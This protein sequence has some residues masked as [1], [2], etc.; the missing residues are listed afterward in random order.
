MSHTA[1]EPIEVILVGELGK[2]FGKKW[3]LHAS[4][5]AQALRLINVNRRGMREY[6]VEAAQRGEKYHVISDD[7]RRSEAELAL[8]VKRRLVIAPAV[9]GAGGKLGAALELVAAA[10]ILVVAWW[11][12]G[13][14]AASTQLSVAAL[15][16]SLALSG[17]TQLLTSIPKAGSGQT[18][19]LQSNYFNGA[20]NTQLQGSAVAVVYGRMLIGSQTISASLQAVDASQAGPETGLITE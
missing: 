18:S 10:V 12:P 4:T 14:W 6:M 20:S 8:P 2:R 13:G 16:G 9:E 11:N 19:S 1:T 15:G 17:I 7:K 5:A 3:T